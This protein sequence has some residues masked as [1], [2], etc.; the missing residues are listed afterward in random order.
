LKLI[1]LSAVSFLHENTHKDQNFRS[2]KKDAASIRAKKHSINLRMGE[3]E[4]V[5][6][7]GKRPLW[8]TM[9]AALFFTLLFYMFY[10]IARAWILQ[11]MNADVVLLIIQCFFGAGYA[12]AGG[13]F[14][15]LQ[16]SVY[17]DL[18]KNLLV[19]HYNVGPISWKVKSQ[20]PQLEYVSVFLDKKEYFEVNLWYYGNRHYNMY[21]FNE[22][23]DAM[24]FAA[25]VAKK[26]S[27]DL[28]DATKKNDS[29]WI[30]ITANG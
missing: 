19:S 1:R 18:D 22:K 15:A 20:V 24:K 10:K 28:L 25:D 14:Y 5:V 17:I 13:V 29:K 30:E 8:R 9:V 12:I 4:L 6:S 16:K 2:A 3:Y 21:T 7:E 23:S 26:L 27:I 11:G